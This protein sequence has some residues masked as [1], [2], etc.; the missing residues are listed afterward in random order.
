[1]LYCTAPPTLGCLRQP[2]T[3]KN[4]L[5]ADMLFAFAR[6][7]RRSTPKNWIHALLNSQSQL[8]KDLSTFRDQRMLPLCCDVCTPSVFEQVIASAAVHAATVQNV[9]QSPLAFT[10]SCSIAV[11]LGDGQAVFDTPVGEGPSPLPQ[12][13]D[14]SRHPFACRCMVN[15]SMGIGGKARQGTHNAKRKAGQA[16]HVQ[17]GVQK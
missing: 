12:V 8:R 13:L 16:R 17:K 6:T 4:R 11:S 2:R 9:L 1:M 10:S 5:C 14:R 7:P 15:Y 3:I